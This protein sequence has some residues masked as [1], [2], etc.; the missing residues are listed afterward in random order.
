MEVVAERLTA[1]H[2][3]Y[4]VVVR[5]AHPVPPMA[6]ARHSPETAMAATIMAAIATIQTILDGH[7]PYVVVVLVS[8]C[9]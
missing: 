2:V 6:G 8:I 3:D 9:E 7:S 1:L 4:A 5:R